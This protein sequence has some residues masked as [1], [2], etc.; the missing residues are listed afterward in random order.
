MKH[1]QKVTIK[2]YLERV[3]NPN[4]SSKLS[5]GK[6]WDEPFSEWKEWEFM[7][8][9]KPKEGILIGKRVL[10]NGIN[11]FHDSYVYLPK[12]Y[13]TAYMVSLDMNTNPVYVREC[14]INLK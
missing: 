14:D 7:P 12:E 4:K 2:G 8:Y 1:G 10:S 13:F 3:S 5:S 11:H 9:D 6:E